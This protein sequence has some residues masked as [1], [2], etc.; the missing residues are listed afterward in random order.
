MVVSSISA[1]YVSKQVR[2]TWCWVNLVGCACLPMS[3]M[4]DAAQK[5]RWASP[6]LRS[7]N[8]KGP[9]LYIWPPRPRT[10]KTKAVDSR[11]PSLQD[12]RSH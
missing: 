7:L 6:A 12:Q 4:G 5:R 11:F 10:T 9:A 8:P 1:R 2:T 3:G